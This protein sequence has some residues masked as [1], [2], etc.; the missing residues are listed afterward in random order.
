MSSK[1]GILDP[2]RVRIRRLQFIVGLGFLSLVAGSMVSVALA[3][4]LS[5]RIQDI[6]WELPQLLLGVTI[7]N[8]WV[9][10]ALPLM[11]YAAARI[12]ELKPLSTALGAAGSGQFFVLSLDFI[13]DGL[14]GMWNGWLISLLNVAAFSG[15]VF[16]SHRAVAKARAAATQAAAK[17]QAQ[18]EARKV[19]YLEF[20]REAERGGE[21][22]AQREAQQAPVAASV[23]SAAVAMAPPEGGAPAPAP[24]EASAAPA[25]AEAAAPASEPSSAPAEVK[26]AA[27]EP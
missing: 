27:N 7:Q 23:G 24:V 21:K 22:T 13:R 3:F 8:L 6:P 20:L 2:L 11:C 18:A 9:L 15:G 25:P 16:L 12:L 14:A 17:A 26:P 4:R 19:E 5:T 1:S 10:G